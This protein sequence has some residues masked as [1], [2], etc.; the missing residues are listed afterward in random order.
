[1]GQGGVF[2]EAV[3]QYLKPYAGN[4]NY[5]NM[6][7]G[8]LDLS[9]FRRWVD[10]ASQYRKVVGSTVL[11][12]GCGSAGD[13]YAFMEAGARNAHGIE[14]D[15][16]LAGLAR[17]RFHG[18]PY[19]N[20]VEIS[21]YDGLI[22]PY[23]SNAFDI[24]FSMH[25]IEHTQDPA[26]YLSELFRVL[27][28]GGIVFLDVP[29]RYYKVEQHTLLPYL[30]YPPTVPRNLLIRTMLSP[31]FSRCLSDQTK[32]K[33]ATYIDIH[34]PSPA[35]LMAIYASRRTEEGLQL[36]DVFYHSY[37]TE[38]LQYRPWHDGYLFGLGRRYTTFRLI[39]SKT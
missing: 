15:Q 19:D 12:S 10:Q 20:A 35:Q 34:F 3:E 29:N 21:V 22:L 16:D 13:L 9:R 4:F 32:Y 23:D 7:D 14:I 26:L 31:L 39:V 8:H 37:L 25:V 27:R 18:S 2:E 36:R 6:L 11:S 30:H 24:V 5:E 33:L 17:K 28:P 38:Q 1:M